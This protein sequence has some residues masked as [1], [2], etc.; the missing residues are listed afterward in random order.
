MDGESK[1][2]F[3]FDTSALISLGVVGLI[4]NVIKTSKIIIPVGVLNELEEFAKYKDKYGVLSQ[5]ILGLKDKFDIID[6][7]IQEEIKHVSKTDNE[8]YNLSKKKSLP[9]ITDD[10]KLI[11]HLDKKT[12][13]YFST[14]FLFTLVLSNNLSKQKALML[15]D[16]LNNERNWQNN[17]IYITSKNELEN[18]K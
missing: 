7:E 13:T 8:V 15:L 9:L 14:Y 2:E 11:R 6:V 10:I 5:D 3:V 1:D 12:E 16:E 17:I 4:E 18:I